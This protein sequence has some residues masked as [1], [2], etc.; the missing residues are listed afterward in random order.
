M[1]DLEAELRFYKE[2][3]KHFA[4]LLNVTDGGQYRA[5]WDSAIARLVR[6]RDEAVAE[7]ERLRKRLEKIRMLRAAERVKGMVKKAKKGRL[8]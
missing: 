7:V 5:D 2:R 8:R 6:E 3:E 4:K 1:V